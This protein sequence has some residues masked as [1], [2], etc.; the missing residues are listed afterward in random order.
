MTDSSTTALDLE[1]CGARTGNCLRAALA[2]SEAGLPY[3]IRRMNLGAGEHRAPAFLAVNAAGKV[4][5]LLVHEA[6]GK[7]PRA[8]SQSSAILFYADDLAPG[9]LLPPPGTPWWAKALE[10]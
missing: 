4:P 9:R 6:S 8:L 10:A 7:P 3:R 1:L 2:L 5:V